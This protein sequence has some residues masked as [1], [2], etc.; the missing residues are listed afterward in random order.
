MLLNSGF[1]FCS[2]PTPELWL[3]DTM[4]VGAEEYVLANLTV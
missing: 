4:T 2:D 3:A 1:M